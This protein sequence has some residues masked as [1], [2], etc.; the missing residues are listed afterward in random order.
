MRQAGARA[1]R[2]RPG[3]G[4]ASAS[5]DG[6]AAGRLLARRAKGK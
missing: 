6:T 4:G 3:A 1:L 2:Y 5:T